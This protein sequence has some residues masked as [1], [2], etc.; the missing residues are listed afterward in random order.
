MATPASAAA[1][2]ASGIHQLTGSALPYDLSLLDHES[3]V[4]SARW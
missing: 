3:D 2:K 4:L 1:T